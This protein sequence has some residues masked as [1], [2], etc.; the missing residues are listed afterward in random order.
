MMLKTSVL[1]AAM[2][3]AATASL[4]QDAPQTVADV[5]AGSADH[6]TLL[7]AVTAAG[8]AETL[9]G[10]GPFTVFAPTDAAF[11][12]VPADTLA[13]VMAPEGK[14]QLAQVLGCHVVAGKLMAA[15]VAAAI[16]A[17]NGTAELT[18]I[19]NCRLTATQ[20]D[21]KVL[22]NGVVEVTGA[23]LDA[24]NGVVHSINGVLLP[25]M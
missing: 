6:T 17:G 12:A 20:A 9:S 15:D 22:L 21:G 4:A 5:V 14:E 7:K 16:E 25:A 8:L 3:L 19:G 13:A 10:E 23:D 1:A 11:A 24:G 18:T 2:A